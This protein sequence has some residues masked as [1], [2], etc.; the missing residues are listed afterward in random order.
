GGL[1]ISA[2]GWLQSQ[3]SHN[4]NICLFLFPM[5]LWL[6]NRYRLR[7]GWRRAAVCGLG[8]G[9]IIGFNLYYQVFANLI[10]AALIVRELSR[11][12]ARWRE[13]ALIGMLA[14][15][16]EFPLAYP[17]LALEKLQSSYG[18]GDQEFM[19]FAARAWSFLIR[20]HQ[21]SWVGR[22]LPIY[23]A[24]ETNLE[25]VGFTG[26]TW[27]ALCLWA[28]LRRRDLRGWLAVG[29]FFY[30]ASLGPKFGVMYP[31]K[32]FP[33]FAALRAIGRLQFLAFLFTV[34]AVLSF[35]EALKKA[36][37][38]PV[39]LGLVVLEL[40]PAHGPSLV[41]FAPQLG[42]VSATAPFIEAFHPAPATPFLTYPQIDTR[43]QLALAGTP[44]SFYLGYSGRE[45]SVALLAREL[46]ARSLSRHE[47][48]ELLRQFLPF[49]R[50]LTTDERAGAVL[51]SIPWLRPLGCAALLDL[52]P[53]VFEVRAPLPEKD[54][55]VLLEL[56]RDATW[57]SHDSPGNHVALLKARRSG[58]LDSAR[59]NG[60]ALEETLKIP[61][62]PAFHQKRGL[63]VTYFHGVTYREGE[64]IFEKISKQRFLD[65]PTWIRP[66]RTYRILCREAQPHAS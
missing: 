7:P 34:P 2:C 63:P 51:K 24:P 10:L 52:R 32:L 55:P 26:Y 30:L 37:L 20:V 57:E 43:L 42:E 29:A 6:W 23:P 17:Y 25:V 22:L 58:I 14:A 62:L 41:S 5:A 54:R 15:A 21:E 49:E 35:L 61:L 39:L 27:A 11:S 44:A 47:D 66:I 59:L 9:W 53:C 60:C 56:D 13:L 1:L 45:T 33:G 64:V 50:M 65:L 18:V 48:L 19:G 4:Q 38:P 46:M 40:I 12:R 36:W 16:V 3:Y 8:F 31:L 28:G